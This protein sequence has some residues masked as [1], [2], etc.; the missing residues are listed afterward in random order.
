MK[1]AATIFCVLATFLLGARL[2]I[3]IVRGWWHEYRSRS[4]GTMRR[5]G[6]TKSA[7]VKRWTA[8]T[9]RACARCDLLPFWPHYHARWNRRHMRAW[10][11]SDEIRKREQPPSP[12]QR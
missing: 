2:L 3:I 1:D 8:M 6:R 12:V 7:L 11:S 10:V 9:W 4:D 5:A